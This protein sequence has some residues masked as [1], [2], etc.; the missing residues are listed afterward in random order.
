MSDEQQ[1][2]DEEHK[3]SALLAPLQSIQGNI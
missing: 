3:G 2:S 1:H